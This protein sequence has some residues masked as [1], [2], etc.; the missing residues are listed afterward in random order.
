[1]IEHNERLVEIRR[2]VAAKGLSPFNKYQ[3]VAEASQLLG[4]S[5]NQATHQI[6]DVP[7]SLY[8]TVSF[9][10][11]LSPLCLAGVTNGYL[12]PAW[13]RTLSRV[14]HSDQDVILR[15]IVGTKMKPRAASEYIEIE[16]SR[17]T[18]TKRVASR[19]TG[20]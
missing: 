16:C 15:H 8:T 2:E 18:V 7:V 1:M 3:L 10:K 9:F 17:E 19:S 11:E 6:S 5:A 20:P 12:R 4:I 14:G 13:C